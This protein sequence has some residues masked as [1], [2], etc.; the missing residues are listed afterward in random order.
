MSFGDPIPKKPKE[1]EWCPDLNSAEATVWANAH[2]LE[3]VF[4][5][6][7]EVFLDMDDAESYTVFKANLELVERF[8]KSTHIKETTSRSGNKH[9]YVSFE[10]DISVMERL[11]IQGILGSDRRCIGHQMRKLLEGDPNPVLFFEKA[12]A[13]K[14]L[15]SFLGI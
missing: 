8:I 5:Q 3:V 9:V 14:R 15:M 7:N 4:P 6:A 11:V 10:R 2:G 1:Q 13:A 12:P